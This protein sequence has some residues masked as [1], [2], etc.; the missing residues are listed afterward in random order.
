MK[1]IFTTERQKVSEYRVLRWVFE[2][3]R[4]KMTE[5]WRRIQDEE[6]HLLSSSPHVIPMIIQTD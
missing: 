4:D 6:L 5:E 3:K 1:I 2:P